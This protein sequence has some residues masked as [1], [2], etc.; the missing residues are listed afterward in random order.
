VRQAYNEAYCRAPTDTETQ[1][2]ERF[3]GRQTAAVAAEKS[4]GDKYLPIPLPA[5]V[6]RAKSAAIVDFCHAIFCSN[7]FLYVD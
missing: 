6:D 4:G 3:I 2:A 7:E 1:A 5:S